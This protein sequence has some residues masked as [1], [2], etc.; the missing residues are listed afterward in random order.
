VR[1]AGFKQQ[2]NYG[3]EIAK[4]IILGLSPQKDSSLQA[5]TTDMPA[6]K[7]VIKWLF[8]LDDF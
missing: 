4:K 2:I 6:F 5:F 8:A 3:H 1:L 7:K